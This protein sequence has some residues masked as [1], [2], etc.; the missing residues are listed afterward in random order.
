MCLP[1]NPSVQFL[2]SF[3]TLKRRKVFLFDI[4]S[5]KEDQISLNNKINRFARVSFRAFPVL[6]KMRA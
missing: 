3:F 4:K 1:D 6:S 2:Y 5:D